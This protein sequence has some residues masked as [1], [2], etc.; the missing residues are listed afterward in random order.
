MRPSMHAMVGQPDTAAGALK[1]LESS[2]KDPEEACHLA[3]KIAGARRRPQ[4]L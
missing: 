4:C 3:R 2:F 1:K